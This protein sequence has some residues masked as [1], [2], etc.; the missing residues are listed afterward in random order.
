M[1]K[2]G[3]TG[4]IGSGKTTVSRIFE[5]LNI[6][7]FYA[8]VEAKKIIS[9]NFTV[10]RQLKELLGEEAYHKNGKADKKYIAEKIFSNKDL[11]AQMNKIVH[12]AVNTS[13]ERW[14]E[15]HKAAG[16]VPYVIKE[17]ALLVETGSYKSLDMLIVVTCPENIRIKRVMERDRVSY[18][19]V[20]HRI[21]NQLPEQT[22]VDVANFV[23]NND[24]SHDLL[25]QVMV[26]HRKFVEAD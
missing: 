2:V 14:I 21:K 17:A 9:S 6:P 26:F 8:D 4:G 16:K 20:T 15:T 22:K 25:K 11:L 3:I 10:K 24:G 13:C 7:V 12:P 18:E 1:K 23:I 5:S 19:E